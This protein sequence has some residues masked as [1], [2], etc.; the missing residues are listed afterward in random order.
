MKDI[1]VRRALR[2]QTL[3]PFY[4]D[5]DSRVVEEMGLCQ[6]AARIDVAVI[7]GCLHGYEIKSERDT[8]ARLPQQSELYNRIFD[9]LTLVLGPSHVHEA[10]AAV[11]R[12]WGISV[13]RESDRGFRVVNLRSAKRNKGVSG[14]HLAQ[15]LW[16]DEA[17]QLLKR[18][19]HDRGMKS[20]PRAKI[21]S[22]LANILQ[23]EELR[24]EVRAIL[25]ARTNWQSHEQ[26]L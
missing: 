8:L 3:S 16:K 14:Y 15:L 25:K 18:L 22:T 17:L 21:W 7:N 11:P 6:G 13:V 26:P 19:G 23:I 12:W 10:T 24:A 20:K 1:D 9:R 4:A 5:P 2:A